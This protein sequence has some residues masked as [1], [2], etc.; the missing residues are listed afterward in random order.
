MPTL[1]LAT[2]NT[3]NSWAATRRM[4]RRHPHALGL[5]E[6]NRLTGRL[7]AGR[8]YRVTTAVAGRDR[9][10]T[11]TAMLVRR[12]LPGMGEVSLLASEALR[13]FP[14]VA[15]DRWVASAAFRHPIGREGVAVIEWHPVAGTEVLSDPGKAAH[16][17]VETYR[18]SRALVGQLIRLY[19]LMGLDV[20]L[21]G[22]LQL[23]AGVDVPWSPDALAK[24]HGM[25][26]TS[27]GLDWIMWPR[28][29]D[30]IQ[31]ETVRLPDHRGLVVSLRGN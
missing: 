10:A 17:L 1:V 24:V 28:D 13:A 12:G 22:D 11:D 27:V 2:G 4:V 19:Q 21:M 6:V 8:R 7:A 14:R 20:C 16:P 29:W 23:P 15:P 3:R 9:R 31:R 25:K 26:R 5:S 30:M 18:E